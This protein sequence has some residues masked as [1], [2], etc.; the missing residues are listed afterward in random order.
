M[1]V[2]HTIK[3]ICFRLLLVITLFCILTVAMNEAGLREL[4]LMR[5]GELRNDFVDLPKDVQVIADHLSQVA[6]GVALD[7]EYAMLMTNN[8]NAM[9]WSGQKVALTS[10]LLAYSIKNTGGN[11]FTIFS[12]AH[13]IG[14][15]V[16]GDP[17]S[18][19]GRSASEQRN[20]ERRADYYGMELM[21]KAGYDCK[22]AA[23]DW[24]A[25]LNMNPGSALA[26]P[27]SEHPG[28]LERMTNA[29][30]ICSSLKKTNKM[31]TDLYFE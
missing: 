5:E 31:P 12:L 19:S 2:K 30:V 7:I 13:E 29:Q 14:H 23:E 27:E 6:G 24:E 17:G 26:D 4:R 21:H 3:E 8:I 28:N 10:G 20:I 25:L 15:V 9:A 22:Y 16:Y 11:Y 18:S 1:K